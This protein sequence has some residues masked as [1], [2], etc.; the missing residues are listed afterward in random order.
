[1]KLDEFIEK[2]KLA[3]SKK[4]LYVQGCFGAP[5]TAANKK[6]YTKKNIYNITHAGAINSASADTF[7]F[8]CICLIKGCIGGWD[9][10]LNL[11][12][13]GTK[14]KQEKNGIS[15]GIDRMPDYGADNVMKYCK[16]VSK[17]FSNIQKGEIVHMSGH[18]GIYLGGGVVIECSPKW[19][20]GVQ[21]TNLGNLGFKNGNWRNWTNHGFLPWIDY[22]SNEDSILKPT[23]N[24]LYYT[25]VKNDNLTKIAIKFDTTVE[26]LLKLNPS[27][28]NPN[29]IY[30][31]QK[32]RVK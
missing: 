6:R 2:L 16:N 3:E 20:N 21:Y 27:I 14:V 8:D 22:S 24:A 17:D 25:V 32:I 29:K 18:V 13:G 30:V 15:Y 11:A 12:Y 31:N 19:K 5:L 1:M 9:G 26:E 7:G 23:D 28:K 10:S 4:T